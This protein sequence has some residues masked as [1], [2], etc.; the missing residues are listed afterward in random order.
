MRDRPV[1]RLA[2]F[3]PHLAGAVWR[4]TATRL[5]TVHQ[6]LYCDDPKSAE[7][8]LINMNLNYD[9]GTCSDGTDALM[10]TLKCPEL[11]ERVQLQLS[12]CDHDALRGAL[13]ADSQGRTWRG[14]ATA[15]ERLLA[16]GPS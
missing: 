11:G 6:E 15:V 3:R 8:A 5:S 4:G 13:K 14:E 2:G 7:I 9:V 1:S 12:V 10:L 16:L